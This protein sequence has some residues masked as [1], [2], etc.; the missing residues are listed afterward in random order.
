MGSLIITATATIDALQ[1][2]N[3]M[4]VSAGTS[5]LASDLNVNATLSISG[6]VLATSTFALST[7]TLILSGGALTSVSGGGTVT[8]D[9]SVS[10]ASYIAFGAGTW[11]F[12]GPAA[13]RSTSTPWPA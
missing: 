12:R 2:F 6:G 10:A 8:G 13:T 1:A 3:N 11:P 4:T 7:M 9:V 5:T